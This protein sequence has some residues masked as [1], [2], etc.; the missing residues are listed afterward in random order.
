MPEEIASKIEMLGKTLPPEELANFL[1][2]VAN[3]NCMYCQISRILKQEHATEIVDSSEYEIED[4]DLNFEQW[5]VETISD[6]MYHVINKLDPTEHY[7]V[8]LG[9]PIGCT[10]GKQNC[11]HIVAVLRH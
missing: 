6:K 10:C 1:H 4:E 5:Q 2:P 7:N 8:Y 3:C 9:D 11:E